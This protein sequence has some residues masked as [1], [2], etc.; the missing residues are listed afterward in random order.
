VPFDIREVGKCPLT[1]HPFS[2][3][4]VTVQDTLD[5]APT[6][7]RSDQRG[8]YV[9]DTD[10]VMAVLGSLFGTQ[11]PGEP[12]SNSRRETDRRLRIDLS[13]PVPG[14]GA[15]ASG[16]VGDPFA[17]L[18]VYYRKD[19]RTDSLFGPL[20]MAVGEEVAAGRVELVFSVGE[21]WERL[22][23]LSFGSLPRGYCE[24]APT[25]QD[26]TGTT[27]PILKRVSSTTWTVRLP[28]ESIGRLWSN[29]ERADTTVGTLPHGLYRSSGLFEFSLLPR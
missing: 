20:D 6:H 21:A 16:V 17:A 10:G 28:R 14:S 2:P 3:I 25:V 26:L 18:E 5:G 12:W 11:V 8:P 24:G 9:N 1:D 13:D 19:S 4:G 23:A 15:V 7:L 27:P 22:W 29:M